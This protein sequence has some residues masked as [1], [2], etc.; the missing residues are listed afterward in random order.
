MKLIDLTGQ[1]FGKLTVIDRDM[2]KTNKVYWICSCE[3]GNTISVYSSYLRSGHT[4]SCG[5]LKKIKAK[6]IG[7]KNKNDL[8]GKVFT[9]LQVLE[10]S[11]VRRNREIVWKCQCICGKIVYV[12]SSDLTKNKTRSCGCK[13]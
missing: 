13:K 12:A 4:Q 6:E 8:I 1:K 5:C 3:C 7:M 2:T 9:Y 11:G 10:D